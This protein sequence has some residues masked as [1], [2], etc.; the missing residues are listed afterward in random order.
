MRLISPQ[1]YRDNKQINKLIRRRDNLPPLNKEDFKLKFTLTNEAGITV[2]VK[3]NEATLEAQ[4][5]MLGGKL[6][7]VKCNTLQELFAYIGRAAMPYEEQREAI[8]FY[9]GLQ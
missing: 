1:I 8:E 3:F 4:A 9:E 7:A 6:R 2:E 5:F